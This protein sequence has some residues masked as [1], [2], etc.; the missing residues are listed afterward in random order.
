[1][2]IK[3]IMER[4]AALNVI[5][6]IKHKI[7]GEDLADICGE[8]S[9]IIGG[10]PVI[11]DKFVQAVMCG[12]VYWDE[13]KNC[14]VQKLIKPVKVGDIARDSLYYRNHLNFRMMKSF[15]SNN[16]VE[17]SVEAIAAI[18][19]CPKQVIDEIEGQDQKIC[20][21]CVDFFS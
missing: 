12:L 13:E 10:S 3:K 4:E 2:E 18:T 7:N 6:K 15:K 14:L 9:K 1:M 19:A 16:E 17:T 21:A 11:Y 8:E 20:A 5:E